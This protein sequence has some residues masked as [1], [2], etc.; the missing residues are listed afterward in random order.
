MASNIV[1][2]TRGKT[3]EPLAGTRERAASPWLTATADAAEPSRRQPSSPVNPL[4][5]SPFGTVAPST[6]LGAFQDWWL[7]V[8]GSPA[9][10]FELGRL[11]SEEW[12]HAWGATVAGEHVA[13]LPQDKRFA[14]PAWQRPPYDAIA[15]NFLLAERWWQR[16]TTDV[17]GRRPPSRADGGF[18]ARQWLDMVAP[19]NFI[20]T[21]P[22]VQ[23]AHARRG[24][25]EPGPRRAAR[26]RGPLARS[27][28]PAAG[29]RRGL[30][31]RP[32]GRDHAGTRRPAQPGHGADPVRADDAHGA[33]RA[34]ARRAGLDHEVLRARPL[35]AATR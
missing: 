2:S 26:R 19:S 7:H 30:R 12:L 17:P 11:A 10:Q 31:A 21:N 24:R 14:D 13:P 16:A 5:F 20:S 3:L 29:R 34:G 27:R 1:A 6:A 35:A 32:H 8:A 33:C 9:K 18:A 4:A 28:R 25:N 22:V 15:R 23:R